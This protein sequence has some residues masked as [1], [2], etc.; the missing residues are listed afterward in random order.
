M[1]IY[2]PF[3]YCL[4]CPCLQST[5]SFHG[6]RNTRLGKIVFEVL[7]FLD[8]LFEKRISDVWKRV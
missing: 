3:L 4:S 7:L 8:V 5:L 6:S 1:D 2:L